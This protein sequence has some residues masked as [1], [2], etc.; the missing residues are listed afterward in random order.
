M[1]GMDLRIGDMWFHSELFRDAAGYLDWPF[2]MSKSPRLS[3]FYKQHNTRR[4]PV[5]V[6]MP[7]KEVFCVDGMCW[8]HDRVFYEGWEVTGEPPL[9]TVS[10][11]INIL[12]A[13]H[14]W[15]R[16]G[17]ISDD[18]EGRTYE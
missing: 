18:C 5:L 11:S 8:N 3:D 12:G 4:E 14:G 16:D 10:P 2:M 13:Y 15:I 1:I 7:C 17:I 9:I 6:W